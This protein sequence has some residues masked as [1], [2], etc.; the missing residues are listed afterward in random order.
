MAH[1][2]RQNDSFEEVKWAILKCKMG[3]FASIKNV[4][5]IQVLCFQRFRKL[6]NF[7]YLRPQDFYFRIIDSQS[8]FSDFLS[9]EFRTVTTTRSQRRQ[10]LSPHAATVFFIS[11]SHTSKP[12]FEYADF[13]DQQILV[14]YLSWDSSFHST[15][16]LPFPHKKGWLGIKSLSASYSSW[17]LIHFNHFSL[18][19]TRGSRRL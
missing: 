3:H 9:K 15:S 5:K 13:D 19:W 1:S 14:C 16:T 10:A 12:I 18:P 4:K 7:A 11:P 8:T 17:F 2:A 6:S